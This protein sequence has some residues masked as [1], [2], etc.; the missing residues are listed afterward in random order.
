MANNQLILGAGKAAKK[1]V[2]VGAEVGKG[3]GA[4]ALGGALLGPSK[5]A[6]KNK[7]YESKVNT[8]MGRMKT[9]MDFTSFSAN[10][11]S[12]MRNFLVAERGK[13]TNA[14]KA[15][16]G[17]TDTTS[18]EYM[19]QV[20]V[21]NGV[22]NSFTNLAAQLKSYKEGKATFAKDM[23][24]GTISRGN[25][26]QNTKESMVMYGFI[27]EDG[28]G[29][30]DKPTDSPFSIQAGG[31]IGFD[32][33]GRMV[34]Y[35]TR[36]PAIMKDYVLSN[37]LLTGNE[38]AY[39]AKARMSPTSQELYRQQLEE[40]FES[41]DALMSMV[42]DFD[43]IVTTQ[44]LATRWDESEN[45][46]DEINSIKE[47]LIN[48]LVEARVEV[49]NKGY[50]ENQAKDNRS[51]KYADYKSTNYR[52]DDTVSPFKYYLVFSDGTEK[53]V[54]KK[55]RDAQLSRLGVTDYPG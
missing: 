49:S 9:D 17:M 43:S 48:R 41:R 31:N 6:L 35:N 4:A 42:Y 30:N 39:K 45:S 25:P 28:D 37:K 18:P 33:D 22:N 51:S 53:L 13:Y 50:N 46:L 23:L 5:T 2:D 20:D 7:E 32:I 38:S 3:L 54:G 24:D 11:T 47:D 29:V 12:S 14:A 55:R 15:L 8:L 26:T 16:A 52:T 19:A 10:E 1:F 44:D 40:D 36:K 27:D 34:D 21:M